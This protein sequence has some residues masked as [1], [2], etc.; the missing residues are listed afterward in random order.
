MV[1]ALQA[2]DHLG[3][4]AAVAGQQ[5]RAL[6]LQRERAQA[7]ARARRAA[8]AR[9]GRARTAP[10]TGHGADRDSSSSRL[11]CASR[12]IRR[13]IKNHG[14]TLNSS[15]AIT[16]GFSRSISWISTRP[17][18]VPPQIDDRAVAAEPDAADRHHEVH[19]RV[20]RAV[21]LD[22]GEDQRR[23]ADEREPDHA[24]ARRTTRS[25]GTPAR[26]RP[27][28]SRS[29]RSRA[30]RRRAKL[31]FG[32]VKN[33]ETTTVAIA[34]SPSARRARG[35]PSTEGGGWSRKFTRHNGRSPSRGLHGRPGGTVSTHG[36]RRRFDPRADDEEADET[37]AVAA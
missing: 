37:D 16:A 25:A 15:P 12:R 1:R 3:V 28:A 11:R 17:P 6:E 27:S 10:P 20:A 36:W 4:G 7:S 8:R 22:G 14:S 31:G 13:M 33:V 18:T 2:L 23:D 19:A 26:G 32:S 21:G 29:R 5:P 30:G 34:T 9:R 24:R 35:G